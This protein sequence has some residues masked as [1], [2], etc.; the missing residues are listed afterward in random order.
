VQK[1]VK[2]VKPAHLSLMPASAEDAEHTIARAE[3]SRPTLDQN[4]VYVAGKN[5]KLRPF[6]RHELGAKRRGKSQTSPF[7][8]DACM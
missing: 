3:T 1:D 7:Q 6:Y 4:M 2:S 5:L 8:L